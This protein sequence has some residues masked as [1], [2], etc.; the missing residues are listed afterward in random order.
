[1]LE[2]ALLLGRARVGDVP[3]EHR[4]RCRCCRRRPRLRCCR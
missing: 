2:Q 4:L 3:V 1:V